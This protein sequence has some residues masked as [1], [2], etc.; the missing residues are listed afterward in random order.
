MPYL[1]WAMFKA[2]PIGFPCVFNT[3]TFTAAR[4]PNPDRLPFSPSFAAKLQLPALFRHSAQLI[5]DVLLLTAGYLTA[6][7][8]RAAEPL[9]DFTRAALL[10]NLTHPRPAES[11]NPATPLTPFPLL[12]PSPRSTPLQPAS[13]MPCLHPGSTIQPRFHPKL[14]TNRKTMFFAER[15]TGMPT[16]YCALCK[17]P[18]CGRRLWLRCPA[19]TH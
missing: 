14:P 8:L 10:S 1:A 12:H 16:S 7:A 4:S 9:D 6:P 13:T 5:Q 19:G 15:P 11:T 18:P 17:A 3:H 2:R